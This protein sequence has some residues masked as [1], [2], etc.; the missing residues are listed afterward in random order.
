MAREL[1]TVAEVAL[2]LRVGESNV[3]RLIQS[4]QMPHT[5]IGKRRYVV[6]RDQLDAYIAASGRRRR[7]VS[8][9]KAKGDQFER[10]VVRV[11]RANGHPYAE[12]ALRLGAHDDHGDIDG[13]PGFHIECR[14]RGRIELGAWMSLAAAEARCLPSR[15]TPV[16]VIKT[17]G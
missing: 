16:L 9:E 17:A 6:S 15:P 12:R 3:Y 13:V 10:D 11:L 4:G 2:E 14:D 1:L 8:R 5:R 7:L